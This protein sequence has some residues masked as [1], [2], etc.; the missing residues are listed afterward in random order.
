MLRLAIVWLVTFSQETM[1]FPGLMLGEGR[2]R[3]AFRWVRREKAGR[4]K[5]RLEEARGEKQGE[6]SGRESEG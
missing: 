2:K 5:E 3:E 1:L 4:N 6:G